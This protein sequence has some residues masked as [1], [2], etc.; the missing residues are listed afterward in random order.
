MITRGAGSLSR[1]IEKSSEN[2]QISSGKSYKG[3]PST[4]RSDRE[5]DCGGAESGKK[6]DEHTAATPEKL[7]K[8][9]S[10]LS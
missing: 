8:C 3:K 9:L 7:L 1:K 2:S 6:A 10:I 5:E 4:G